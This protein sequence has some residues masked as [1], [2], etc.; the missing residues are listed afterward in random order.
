MLTITHRKELTMTDLDLSHCDL[1]FGGV[2]PTCTL[3]LES[4][5]WTLTCTGDTGPF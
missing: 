1:I 2:M 3:D 5:P 4:N